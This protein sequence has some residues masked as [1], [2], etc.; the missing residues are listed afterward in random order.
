MATPLHHLGTLE[1]RLRKRVDLLVCSASFEDRCLSIA[2]NLDRRRVGHVLVVKNRRFAGVVEKNCEILRN[3]F[4]GRETTV[5]VDS[6]DPVVT[7]TNLL[8]AVQAQWGNGARRIVIDITTF[9]H[10][11]LLILFR[12]GSLVFDDTSRVE[13][14]YVPAKEYSIGDAPGDKWLSKGISEVRSVMG[15]PGGFVPSRGTHLIVLAGF[16]DYRALSLIQELEPSV[17]SIGYGDRA[18]ANTAPHQLTNEARVERIRS[19]LGAVNNFVFSCY[20][21]IGA[22]RTIRGVVRE[23][24]GYNTI[25]APM[26]TKVS[27]LGAGRVALKDESIQICYAQADMYNYRHY[28]IPGDGYYHH[29]FEDYPVSR[30]P[31]GLE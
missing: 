7:T 22:E 8:R 15:Y 26:N 6:V 12:V 20:D 19:V 27:T 24:E 1:K 13:F 17:V 9:T 3:W 10:E 28:S 5:E 30:V 18:D 25:L 2:E 11:T 31:P 4:V 16:E 14:L 29:E 21:A 23:R